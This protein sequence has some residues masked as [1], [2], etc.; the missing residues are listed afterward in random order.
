MLGLKL[1]HVSKRGP[2][3]SFV[4]AV[5]ARLSCR[6]AFTW[7][8]VLL[9][10]N[11]SK[12]PTFVPCISVNTLRPEHNVHN[13]LDDNLKC[14]FITWANVDPV[15]WRICMSLALDVLMGET[16]KYE[17]QR[18]SASSKI[19]NLAITRNHTCSFPFNNAFFLTHALMKLCHMKCIYIIIDVR[20]RLFLRP[21]LSMQ[22][23]IYKKRARPSFP[24]KICSSIR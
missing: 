23:V 1:I 10:N 12:H 2:G 18:N 17:E 4:G 16:L 13:C 19:H 15:H 9:E 3:A 24:P 20:E 21:R 14:T 7:Q 22:G 5:I 8:T 6:K 11:M